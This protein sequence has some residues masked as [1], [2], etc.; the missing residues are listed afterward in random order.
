MKGGGGEFEDPNYEASSTTWKLQS[1][2]IA[3]NLRHGTDAVDFLDAYDLQDGHRKDSVGQQLPRILATKPTVLFGRYTTACIGSC[4]AVISML[5][6]CPCE[7]SKDE[8]EC[9]ERS[10]EQAESQ[11]YS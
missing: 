9:D 3:R 1:P 6:N 4:V 11:S 2:V 7:I 5:S 8:K 10:S